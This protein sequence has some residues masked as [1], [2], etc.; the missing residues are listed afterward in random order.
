M[1]KSTATYQPIPS[2]KLH[3]ES[4][5]RAAVQAGYH[6]LHHHAGNHFK[7]GDPAQKVSVEIFYIR[8][9][10]HICKPFHINPIT[11]TNRHIL[12]IIFF[13]RLTD[14]LKQPVNYIIDVNPFC[15][16]VEICKNPMAHYRMGQAAYIATR[17]IYPP[18]EQRFSFCSK[19][20]YL[21]FG[22]RMFPM[23]LMPLSFSSLSFKLK[24]PIS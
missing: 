19:S 14:C 3:T 22:T 23:R 24:S 12:S 10:R 7:V 15:V 5:K 20:S 4:V 21:A 6:P 11:N 16:G 18:I 13:T 17:N 9:N 1:S 8:K 2:R